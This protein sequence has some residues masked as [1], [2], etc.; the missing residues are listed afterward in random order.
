MR[1][2]IHPCEAG[3]AALGPVSKI[4]GL[5]TWVADE[6]CKRGRGRRAQG[7]SDEGKGKL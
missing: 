4:T 1:I 6:V 5:K 3:V 2:A 7:D